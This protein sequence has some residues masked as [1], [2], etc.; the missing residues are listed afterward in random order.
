MFKPGD[1][2]LCRGKGLFDRAVEDV[3]DSPYSHV[4]GIVSDRYVI[5]AQAFRK[6][7]FQRLDYYSGQDVYTCD[8]LTDEQR[9]QIMDYAEAQIGTHYDYLL[10]LW[11]A[12]RYILHVV[13]P[14]VERRRY[15][16]STLWADAYQ[17]AGIELCPGVKYPTPADVAKSPLLRRCGLVQT[18]S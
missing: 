11:E 15:I 5:E 10:V 8:A 6:T 3:T 4:A 13:C 1:L 9:I 7:G 14:Y 18:S 17:V 16:C 12:A 2:V